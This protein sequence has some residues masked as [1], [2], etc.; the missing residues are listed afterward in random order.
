MIDRPHELK[1]L[2]RLLR[3][4][5]VV[6]IV[7]TRQ[8]VKATLSRAF[9]AQT[10]KKVVYYDLENPEDL[11]RLAD[12]MLVLKQHKGVVIIDEVQRMADLFPVLRVLADRPGRPVQFLILESASPAMLRQSSETLAGR[13]AN[14][15][16]N[17]FSLAEEGGGGM[18]STC[19]YGRRDASRGLIYPARLRRVAS[20]VRNS[21][22]LFLKGTSPSLGSTSARRPY[23]DFG[24]C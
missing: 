1:T 7:G 5:P 24:P 13:V 22:A 19:G 23:S 3:R 12:P 20:G 17:G 11:A 18:T 14:R 2:D 9:A 15:K 8:V 4:F 10:G 16:F 6:S 21:S